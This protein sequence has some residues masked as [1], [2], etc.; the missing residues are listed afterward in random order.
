MRVVHIGHVPCP[1]DHPEISRLW[2]NA[3]APSRWVLNLA[4]AQLK[5]TDIQAEIVVKAPG[6]TRKW[7]THVE[8][9][10]CHFVPTPNIL[11]G[12]THFFLDQRILAHAARAL[13]P[14]I[15]HAHGT[16]EANALASLRTGLPCLL[17]VQ[18]CFFIINRS[19]PARFF[20]RQWIVERLERRTIPRFDCIIAKSEYIRQ[21][22]V[23]EFPSTSPILVPNTY[24]PALAEISFTEPRQ[25]AIAF[26][27]SL[28][29]WKGLHLLVDVVKQV[30]EE[31]PCLSLHICGDRPA[32]QNGYE[33]QIK[34]DLRQLLGDHLFLHGVLPNVEAVKVV[35]QCRLL[36]APSL[37]DMFGNQAVE[38]LLVGTPVLTLEGTA[39]AENVRRLGNGVVSTTGHLAADLANILNQPYNSKPAFATRSAVMAWMSPAAVATSHKSIYETLLKTAGH[40][41]RHS[42]LIV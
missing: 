32:V 19:L 33:G 9:V 24:D 39:I 4:K 38:S 5:H 30:L 34:R 12:K 36:M 18:G 20:S 29:A 26:V 31:F 42:T 11:R 23:K 41:P 17:T 37:E 2:K 16:E 15:V 13:Q 28:V 1:P 35:S 14:D 3:F 21:Q 10:L 25:Q 8:G 27:G 40:N 7:Q 6:A 22:L